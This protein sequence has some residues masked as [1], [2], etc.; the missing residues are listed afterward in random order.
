M[1]MGY[2]LPMSRPQLFTRLSAVALLLSATGCVTAPKPLPRPKPPTPAPPQKVS[3][4]DGE[5]VTGAPSITISLAEQRAHFFKDAKEVGQAVISSGKHGFETPTGDFAVIQRD[6]NH[7]SNLYGEFVDAGGSVVKRNVDISKEKPPEGA[8][9]Q[10]A[11]MPFFLRFHGGA[12]MHAGKLPG[13]AASHGCVRLPRFMAEHFFENAPLGTPVR[14]TG[15]APGGGADKSPAKKTTTKPAK[16]PA[17][18]DDTT[19][20]AAPTPAPEGEKK[21]EPEPEKKPEPASPPV[22]PPSPAEGVK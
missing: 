1:T 14:V 17:K 15:N 3:H 8:S 2:A 11:K 18:P 12:G 20:P 4:W 22:V 9:F 21:T 6:K 13:Y 5:G 19:A 10:G 16:T 7:I